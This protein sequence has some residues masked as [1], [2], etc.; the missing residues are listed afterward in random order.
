MTCTAQT[1]SV[2]QPQ[3]VNRVGLLHWAGVLH[4]QPLFIRAS[5]LHRAACGLCWQTWTAKCTIAYPFQPAYKPHTYGYG[6]TLG[7][8]SVWEDTNEIHWGNCICGLLCEELP[9]QRRESAHCLAMYK[10]KLPIFGE[11][12]WK[13]IC[14][15]TCRTDNG[16]ISCSIIRIFSFM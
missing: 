1:W 5:Q 3:C 14:K 12:M 8:F 16:Y 15:L 6:W 4:R 13:W 9:Y 11:P 7:R 2:A 10:K